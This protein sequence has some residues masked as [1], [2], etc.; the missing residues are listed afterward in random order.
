[1][2]IDELWLPPCIETNEKAKKEKEWLH[3]QG[4]V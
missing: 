1:M 2:S 4:Q 3:S